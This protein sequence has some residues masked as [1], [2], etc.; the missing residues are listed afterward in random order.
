MQKKSTQRRAVDYNVS[1]FTSS[2]RSES[3]SKMEEQEYL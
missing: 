1:R 2:P 3:L